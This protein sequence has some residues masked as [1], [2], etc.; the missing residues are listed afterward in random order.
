MEETT[1]FEIIMYIRHGWTGLHFA[2]I[3]KYIYP[4]EILFIF[5]YENV[6]DVGF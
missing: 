5:F 1:T 3:S 6:I 2:D 4:M